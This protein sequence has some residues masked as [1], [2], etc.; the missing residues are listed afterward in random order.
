MQDYLPALALQIFYWRMVA[1]K[2]KYS[3]YVNA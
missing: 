1:T 3:N 2:A